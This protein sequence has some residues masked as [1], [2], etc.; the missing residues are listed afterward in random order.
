LRRGEPE[1]VV[2][3]RKRFGRVLW[4]DILSALMGERSYVRVSLN[5][6]VWKLD[7]TDREREE[8]EGLETDRRRP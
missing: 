5:A 6:C 1:E 7:E 8:E 3:R 2:W 4:L